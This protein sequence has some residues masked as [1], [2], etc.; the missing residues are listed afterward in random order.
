MSLVAIDT[1]NGLALEYVRVS[2]YRVL[3]RELGQIL[4]GHPNE[5]KTHTYSSLCQYYTQYN[6][7][8]I[9]MK[10]INLDLGCSLN[11]V[12]TINLGE[13]TSAP[14]VNAYK[15]LGGILGFS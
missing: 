6:S 3:E 14:G 4:R 12:C 1:V 2:T 15:H 10:L 9:Y 11:N 7:T 13:S 8:H 5:E